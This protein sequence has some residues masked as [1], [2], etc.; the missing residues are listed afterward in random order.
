MVGLVPGIELDINP[1]QK[2]KLMHPDIHV[3]V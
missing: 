2:T 3:F 1:E